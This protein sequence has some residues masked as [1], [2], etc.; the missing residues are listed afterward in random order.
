M[1]PQGNIEIYRVASDAANAELA[2]IS[3]EFERLRIRKEHI[4]K[5]VQVLHPL[6]ADGE[7]PAE[8]AS[9]AASAPN[10]ENAAESSVEARGEAAPADPFQRR[11]DHVLGIGG[12]IRDVRKY[13]RQF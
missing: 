11:V 7:E 4:E 10:T 6:I 2:E 1:K 5:L 13:S 8:L 12:G 3:M 9:V